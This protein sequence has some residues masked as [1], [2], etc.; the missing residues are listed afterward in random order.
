MDKIKVLIVDDSALMRK[1]IMDILKKDSEIEVVSTAMNGF[2]ALNKL[3]TLKPDIITL[4]IEMPEMNGLEFLE[5]KRKIGDETPVI[6][7]SSLTSTGSST[8]MKALELGAKDYLLKP[9]ISTSLDLNSVEEEMIQKIK[10]WAI[11]SKKLSKEYVKTEV[12]L[13]I[14]SSIE[15]IE[16]IQPE[17]LNTITNFENIKFIAIGISTGG[18]EALRQILPRFE[19][20]I[21]IVIVQ[22][23]PEGFTKDFAISLNKITNQNNYFVKEIEDNDELKN[24]YIYIAPG[25]HQI[26]MNKNFDKF[27]LRVNQDPPVNNHRPSVDYFFSSLYKNI[28]QNCFI[29]I[30]MTGMGK[31]GAYYIKKLHDRG[32]YT[33]AQDEE[34]CIVFGMPKSAIQLGGVDKILS[35]DEIPEFINKLYKRNGKI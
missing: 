18:P 20:N 7:F 28:V 32:I 5:E 1:L 16:K 35:L 31:D 21:P 10:N 30:I 34:S 12:D 13:K 26:S 14:K 23:M 29:A 33:I 25:N 27:I 17:K 8:T 6:V 24:N 15:I 9:D 2:F 11:K 4:D 3:K 22:H 19:T